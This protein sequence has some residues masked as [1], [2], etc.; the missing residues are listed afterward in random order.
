MRTYKSEAFKEQA[1]EAML[2][3][4]RPLVECIGEQPEQPITLDAEEF[5][6]LNPS[7]VRALGEN[8]DSMINPRE[9]LWS[10]RV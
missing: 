7:A 4:I 10:P 6:V 2:K 8:H 1:F 5:G 3:K 9:V